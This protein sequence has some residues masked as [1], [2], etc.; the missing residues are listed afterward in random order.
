MSNNIRLRVGNQITPT[1]CEAAFPAVQAFAH[2]LAPSSRALRRAVQNYYARRRR[3][4]RGSPRRCIICAE[5]NLHTSQAAP[6]GARLYVASMTSLPL[7]NGNILSTDLRSSLR[8]YQHSSASGCRDGW[9]CLGHSSAVTTRSLS[10]WQY[11]TRSGGPQ[12]GCP[13]FVCKLAKARWV[14]AILQPPSASVPCWILLQSL[15]LRSTAVTAR[16]ASLDIG[17]TST[18]GDTHIRPTQA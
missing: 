12:L 7:D 1:C 5:V 9:S 11:Y 18:L 8:E 17:A 2:R 10:W 16:R 6:V 14:P 3:L 13:P 15:K 4:S